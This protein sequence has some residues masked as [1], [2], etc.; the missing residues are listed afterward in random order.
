[1]TKKKVQIPIIITTP[2]LQSES[3]I[4][5]K[6]YTMFVLKVFLFFRCA[7]CWRWF[8]R[9]GK[10]VLHSP[11]EIEED[12]KWRR[13]RCPSRPTFQP[14]CL[15]LMLWSTKQGLCKM[16]NM[17][18]SQY[19]FVRVL[20]L[21]ASPRSSSTS[22]NRSPP[23]PPATLVTPPVIFKSA[24]LSRSVDQHQTDQ[25]EEQHGVGKRYSC[26]DLGDQ[27]RSSV[28]RFRLVD[29][30]ICGDLVDEVNIWKNKVC[31]NIWFVVRRWKILQNSLH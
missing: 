1:M 15:S 18:P 25:V 16:A 26:G 3:D 29:L 6:I 27:V 12:E 9:R 28:I 21:L 14:N 8:Q 17:D 19:G 4:K 13:G 2:S 24:K 30:W 10:E 31:I 22:L 23:L 7:P 11:R 20:S 5:W